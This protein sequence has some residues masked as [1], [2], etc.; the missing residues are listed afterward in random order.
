LVIVIG[1]LLYHILMPT[2]LLVVDEWTDFKI[3]KAERGR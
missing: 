2:L 3:L 1:N